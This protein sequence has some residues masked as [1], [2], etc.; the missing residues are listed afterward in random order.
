[1][2]DRP[3]RVSCAER[4]LRLKKKNEKRQDAHELSL[5]V[6]FT[7][8]ASDPEWSTVSVF[9][10]LMLG[11]QVENADNVLHR[12]F[13]AC[14]TSTQD[15]QECFECQECWTDFDSLI[16]LNCE[17]SL[18]NAWKRVEVLSGGRAAGWC[19]PGWWPARYR[20]WS[21]PRQQQSPLELRCTQR[22]S[23]DRHRGRKWE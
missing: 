6:Y 1:M 13:S 10:S 5:R 21:Q 3:P 9:L 18:K 11:P 8:H 12:S 22:R 15:A 16:M 2:M 23:A 19:G 17:W 20:H 7:L 14:V 4:L